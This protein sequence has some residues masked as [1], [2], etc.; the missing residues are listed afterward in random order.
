MRK[1]G[2]ATATGLMGLT[3]AGAVAVPAYAQPPQQDGLVNVSVG[4]VT[5]PIGVAA[6][7]AAN[8]CGISVGP[9]AVLATQVDRGG[10]PVTVCDADQSQ[11]GEDVIITN[12]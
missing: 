7:I 6:Q 10:D 3:L 2:K 1:L 5:V 9:V 4:N 8:A 12:N 11:T